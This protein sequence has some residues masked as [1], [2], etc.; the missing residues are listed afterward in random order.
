MAS[1]VDQLATELAHVMQPGPFAIFGHSLGGLVAYALTRE[2]VRRGTRLPAIVAISATRPPW[3]PSPRSLSSLVDLDDADLVEAL[4]T[5]NRTVG[6][7]VTDRALISF[8]LPVIRSD[9]RLAG[10]LIDNLP[11]DA[12]MSRSAT[13]PLPV[14]TLLLSGEADPL[15]T[16]REMAGWRRYFTGEVS[17]RSYPGGHFYLLDEAPAVLAD[18]RATLSATMAGHDAPYRD[19]G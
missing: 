2:L 11:A 13:L 18:L 10:S 9:L 4:M 12:A 16:A 8:M 5:L 7:P 17:T 3:P 1:L 19:D 15:V 14:P 6:D